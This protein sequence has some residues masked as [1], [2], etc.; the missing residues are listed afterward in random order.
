MS[1]LSE[2]A[3]R[4]AVLKTLLDEVKTAYEQSR[5]EVR[6]AM[7]E[8]GAERVAASLPD[9]TKVAQIVLSQ[10]RETIGVDDRAFLEWVREN[11][12]DELVIPPVTVRSS[13]RDAILARLTIVGG[14]VVDTK[15]GQVV[16]WA[17]VNPA[18]E[19]YPTTKLITGGK[20]AILAAWNDGVISLDALS[21][22]AIER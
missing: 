13:F 18:G 19:P 22:K 17:H 20:E 6:A 5:K 16:E 7:V 11:H 9:G 12:E 1:A 15:T 21:T 4:S 3:A 14:Q 10:P 8:Q 2:A